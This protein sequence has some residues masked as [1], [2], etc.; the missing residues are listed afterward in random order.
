[1]SETDHRVVNETLKA[2]G[3]TN[4]QDM[5][6]R[7]ADIGKPGWIELEPILDVVNEALKPVRK[8]WTLGVPLGESGEAKQR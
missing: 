1:L 3:K 4:P 5:R 2:A 8:K 6:L 7:Y